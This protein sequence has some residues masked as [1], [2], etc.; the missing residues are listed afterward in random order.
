MYWP[1][2]AVPELADLPPAEQKRLWAEAVRDR[3]N[4]TDLLVVALPVILVMCVLG[5]VMLQIEA[6]PAA[7]VRWPLWFIANIL[8]AKCVQWVV[9]RH[10]RRVLR[11]RRAGG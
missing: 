1:F 9:V 10:Y 7:W 5:A 11:R 8:T 2:T 3:S 6:L 4:R